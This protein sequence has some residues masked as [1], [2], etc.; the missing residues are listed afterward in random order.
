MQRT[1]NSIVDPIDLAA[2]F[3]ACWNRHDMAAMARLFLDDAH[4]INVVGIWW[5]SAAEIE[6]AHAQLHAGPFRDS[7][8]EMETSTTRL[9][10][11]GV[12]V[13]HTPWCLRGW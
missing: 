8:L 10:A 1:E 4:M 9:V 5:E 2:A 3:A 6:E 13:V 7:H 11:P 12:V